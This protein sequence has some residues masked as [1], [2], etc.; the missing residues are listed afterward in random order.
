MC[1]WSLSILYVQWPLLITS[2]RHIYF[3]LKLWRKF[4]CIT[5]WDLLWLA[6]SG[7]GYILMSCEATR[8]HVALTTIAGVLEGRVLYTSSCSHCGRGIE[9]LLHENG[10]SYPKR[11][12]IYSHHQCV[13]VFHHVNLNL[14]IG[15]MLLTFYPWR[16]TD[17]LLPKQP[18]SLKHLWHPWRSLTVCFVWS[19]ETCFLSHCENVPLYLDVLLLQCWEG[20]E[21]HLINNLCS[22]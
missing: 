9:Q 8:L 22:V 3:W 16:L 18:E 13:C 11:L 2:P 4:H 19:S 21:H 17:L 7:W 1:L 6:K 12:P 14:K 15:R 20:A 5:K 10:W